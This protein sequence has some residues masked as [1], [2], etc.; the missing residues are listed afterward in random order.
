MGSARIERKKKE[1]EEVRKSSE[2][3][4]EGRYI[5]GRELVRCRGGEGGRGAVG[6]RMKSGRGRGYGKRR[7]MADK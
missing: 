1:R 5:R 4:R 3:G 2:M 6:K 7:E